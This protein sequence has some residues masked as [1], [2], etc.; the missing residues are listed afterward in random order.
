MFCI[1]IAEPEL[2]KIE[3]K[4]KEAVSHTELVEIR[5]DFFENVNRNDLIR[6]LSNFDCKYIFTFR[7]KKEGG[8]KRVSWKK[9]F[10]WIDWALSQEIF[11]LVDLEYELALKVGK[12]ERLKNHSSKLLIS[13]H[14]FKEVPPLKRLL[15]IIEF[16]KKLSANYC[17]IV[18]MVKNFCESLKLLSLIFEAKAKKVKLIS[19]G[20]GE[21]GRLSRILSLLA[22]SPFT[23]VVLKEKEAVAPGQ[24]SLN[25]AKELYETLKGFVGG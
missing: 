15:A 17:K 10:E 11:Y 12:T 5:G 24:L 7:S 16:T 2:E 1:T 4:L 20:M 23:Y 8:K 25:Q 19:F 9:Q 22:G 6:I 21:A 3:K 14:N 13:Y 18:C